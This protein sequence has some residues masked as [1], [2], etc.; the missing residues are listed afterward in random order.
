MPHENSPATSHHITV[1]GGDLGPIPIETR[2]YD[3]PLVLPGALEREIPE[4]YDPH[5][6]ADR[7]K[8]LEDQ[9]TA[10]RRIRNVA[11]IGAAALAA[12]L[13]G[14]NVA[15]KVVGKIV[16]EPALQ[17]IE[18]EFSPAERESAEATK[19]RLAENQLN[20]LEQGAPPQNP[21]QIP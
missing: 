8:G 7:R 1:T 2:F 10:R 13:G 12:G 16:G 6:L 5:H 19:Q 21:T 11:V 17:S 15:G 3:K 20:Q 14:G 18:N 4:T 9:K